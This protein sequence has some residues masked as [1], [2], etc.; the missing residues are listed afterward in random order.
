MNIYEADAE[1]SDRATAFTDPAVARSSK[2]SQTH[3]I[4]ELHEL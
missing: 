4:D 1:K 3:E 2:R